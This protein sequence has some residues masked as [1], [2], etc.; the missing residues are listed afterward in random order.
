[1]GS[2][3]LNNRES[4]DSSNLP[5]QPFP[6]TVFSQNRKITICTFKGLVWPTS[7][8]CS[9]AAQ[10][11]KCLFL[12]TTGLQWMMH[13]VCDYH[14]QYPYTLCSLTNTSKGFLNLSKLPADTTNCGKEFHILTTLIVK[15]P[16]NSSSFKCFSSNI[17]VWPRVFFR[18]I[19][20]NSFLLMIQFSFKEWEVISSLKHIFSK[21]NTFNMCSRFS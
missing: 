9:R 2:C 20:L 13:S 16:L 17:T 1:M 15:N 7:S 10:A 12:Y 6:P 18:D 4:S 3:F 5:L 11:R 14:F 19:R 8:C 21:K